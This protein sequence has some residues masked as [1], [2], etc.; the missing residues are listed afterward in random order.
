MADTYTQLYVQVV[1]AV[2]HRQSL[3]STK[4]ED[5]LY[6][7]MTGIISN[8]NQKLMII[9]GMPDHVHILIGL[10]PNCNLSDLIRDIKSCSTK[11]INDQQ[12]VKGK[13]SW[14]NGFGAF[15]IGQSQIPR[16]V[17][18]IRNQK[19]HHRTKSFMKEYKQFLSAYDIQYNDRYIFKEI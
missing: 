1:F 9:N 13:F 19:E 15:T 17:N 14:Q 4:W 11:W 8:Q 7:Y 18:Y 2:K 10:K 16:V 5:D 6:R 12:L 3:I